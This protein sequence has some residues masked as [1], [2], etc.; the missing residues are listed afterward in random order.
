MA[1][2]VD[3]KSTHMHTCKHIFTD[4]NTTHTHAWACVCIYTQK[5]HIV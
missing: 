3:L 1:A 4:L 5:T 2:K